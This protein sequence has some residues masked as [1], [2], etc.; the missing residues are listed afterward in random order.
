[1]LTLCICARPAAL[2]R[3]DC[4]RAHS[5]ALSFREL[6]RQLLDIKRLR[7]N[8][9]LYRLVTC[10]NS[11]S[12]HRTPLM[13]FLYCYNGNI[14]HLLMTTKMVTLTLFLVFLAFLKAFSGFPS[15]RQRLQDGSFPKLSFTML[16]SVYSGQISP[17]QN[18]N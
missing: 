12:V 2:A 13:H 17:P 18:K 1:M 4:Q 8:Q 6:N 10:C 11:P 3:I 15:N 9:G 16:T 5:L 7:E 14:L